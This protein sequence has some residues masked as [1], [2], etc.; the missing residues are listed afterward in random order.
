MATHVDL[1]IVRAQALV[2]DRDHTKRATFTMSADERYVTVAFLAGGTRTYEIIE[3]LAESQWARAIR[4]SLVSSNPAAPAPTPP[5]PDRP[6]KVASKG[7]TGTKA[8]RVDAPVKRPTTRHGNVQG[9]RTP[10][11]TA[12][13]PKPAQPAQPAPPAKRTRRKRSR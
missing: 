11:S 10:R 9:A 4:G 5:P 13:V 12:P 8:K 1:D 2:H 7:T 3:V 6:T